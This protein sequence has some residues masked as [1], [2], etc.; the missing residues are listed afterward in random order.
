MLDKREKKIV[1]LT[2]AVHGFVHM[3]MLIFAP[4][5]L[6]MAADLGVSMTTIGLIGVASY[7]LFGFGA[8]P[9]GFIID[10]IGARRVIAICVAGMGLA[11]VTIAM[12]PDGLTAM[13]GLAM[14]GFFASLYH[15]AGMGLIS[16]NV[17]ATGYAL[18]VHGLIGESLG[19]IAAGLIGAFLGWR[20]AFFWP[21]VP[22]VILAFI[23]FTTRFGDAGE[24]QNHGTKAERPRFAPGMLRLMLLVIVIQGFAGFIYRSATTFMPAYLGGAMSGVFTGADPAMLGGVLTGLILASGSIGQYI[25]GVASSRRRP[26]TLLL[27]VLAMNA[28][29]LFLLG[30]AQGL[31]LLLIAVAFAMSF[32][33]FQPLGNV[34]V[35]NYS[36]DHQR[37]R[38]YG[39]SFFT[40]FGLGSFGSGFAGYV[41]D[42]QGF[43]AIYLWLGLFCGVAILIAAAVLIL[44]RRA[45]A[46]AAV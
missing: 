15:P 46:V 11:N 23:F 20:E 27:V 32:Y 14:L 33:A 31:P 42:T 18:G 16:R 43:P 12:A 39:L 6:K 4:V 3:Q 24:S 29:L 1:L 34:L 10:K 44:S 41:G 30:F 21:V 2:S 13:F 7:F 35:A 26:E 25:S 8:L 22:M 9:A 36:P 28:P 37:G 19:P 40:S 38:S 5:N 45:K 17:R